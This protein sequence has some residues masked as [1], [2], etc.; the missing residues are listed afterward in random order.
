MNMFDK[1]IHTDGLS[2]PQLLLPRLI[3]LCDNFLSFLLKKL[4]QISQ[5]F[6]K[7]KLELFTL[8]NL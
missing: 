5:I 1:P 7:F 8:L 3:E 2:T 4:R 6:C